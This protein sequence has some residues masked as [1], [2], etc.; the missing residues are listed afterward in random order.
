MKGKRACSEVFQ[1]LIEN[2][3]KPSIVYL[4]KL[5]FTTERERKI[6]HDK[7]KLK[8]YM[9][10]FPALQNILKRIPHT[11]DENKHSHE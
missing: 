3:F 1:T 9:T 8:Q 11:E 7:Q 4:T 5:S 2:N 6:F 10:I